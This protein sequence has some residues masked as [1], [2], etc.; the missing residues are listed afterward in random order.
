MALG[1]THHELAYDDRHT[2][3]VIG[4]GGRPCC[5]L[6]ACARE[7]ERTPRARARSP[8]ISPHARRRGCSSRRASRSSTPP[9]ATP[10]GRSPRRRPRRGRRRRRAACSSEQPP[11]ARPHAAV[12]PGVFGGLRELQR[13]QP[14]AGD[15]ADVVAPVLSSRSAARSSPRGRQADRRRRARALW[16]RRRRRG[17]RAKWGRRRSSRGR[18]GRARRRPNAAAAEETA[19]AEGAEAEHPLGAGASRR[20]AVREPTSG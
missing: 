2:V 15:A 5:I 6:S 10:H 20:S 18:L 16:R 19:E 4:S 1:P 12:A 11:S 8:P 17:R 13:Q 7:A 14:G 3:S 9:C